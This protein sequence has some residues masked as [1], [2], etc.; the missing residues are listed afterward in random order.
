MIDKIIN[1]ILLLALIGYLVFVAFLGLNP[2][3]FR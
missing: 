2:D 3:Y 1:I